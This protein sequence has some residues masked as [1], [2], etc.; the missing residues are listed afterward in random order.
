L[1]PDYVGERLIQ[2]K[3]LAGEEELEEDGLVEDE[4]AK[5]DK[6]TSEELEDAVEDKGSTQLQTPG[7]YKLTYK[8]T[9]EI[10]RPQHA[11]V[12][13]SIQGRTMRNEICLMD[14]DSL[15][16][17]TRDIIV[18]MSRPTK[19]ADLHMMTYAQQKQLLEDIELKLQHNEL[20]LRKRVR[21]SKNQEPSE[22]VT[23]S[24]I[25]RE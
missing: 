23:P 25:G 16:M 5:S 2:D 17:T 24:R 22:R 19:G 6:D 20:D 4:D 9:S 10:M 15:K 21:D 1:H 8:R 11:L 3:P 7:L 13:A 12:Y 14:L 18:A